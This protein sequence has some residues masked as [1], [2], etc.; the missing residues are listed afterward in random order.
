[1]KIKLIDEKRSLKGKGGSILSDEDDDG[2]GDQTDSS[3]SEA[4]AK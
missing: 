2:V 3:D 4:S 1:M